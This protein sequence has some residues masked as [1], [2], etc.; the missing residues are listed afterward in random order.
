MFWEFESPSGSLN[1]RWWWDLL[2][3]ATIWC[4][5][6]KIEAFPHFEN[7]PMSPKDEICLSLITPTLIFLFIINS[8]TI[9]MPQQNY[10]IIWSNLFPMAWFVN[11]GFLCFPLFTIHF[12]LPLSVSFFLI[13]V[14]VLW[15]KISNSIHFSSFFYLSRSLSLS[16]S[17]SIYINSFWISLKSTWAGPQME[18]RAQFKSF[19]SI[20]LCFASKEKGNGCGH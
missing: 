1:W 12:L 3:W 2:R 13:I 4:W 15:L 18:A 20:F 5:S 6:P 10:C 17:H 8:Q 14:L 9:I 19:I 7:H 11:V 16:L